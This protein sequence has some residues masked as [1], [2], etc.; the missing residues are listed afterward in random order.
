MQLHFFN[1]NGS[2]QKAANYYAP[3]KFD[4]GPVVEHVQSFDHNEG[5]TVK[6]HTGHGVF[7]DYLVEAKD[8][9]LVL[10]RLI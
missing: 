7:K 8:A 4:F 10:L 3:G 9:D 2:P 5:E 1:R 6:F